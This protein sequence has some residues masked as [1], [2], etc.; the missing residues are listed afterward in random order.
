VQ[1]TLRRNSKKNGSARRPSMRYVVM[2]LSTLVFTASLDIKAQETAATSVVKLTVPIQRIEN[3]ERRNF[4]EN[5][6]AYAVKKTAQH[7]VFLS[8]W[9]CIDGFYDRLN[10]PT[11]THAGTTIF[12]TLVESGGNMD[13]DWLV[14]RTP[15]DVFSDSL[16]LAH[17]ASEKVKKGE[18]LYGFGW[19][20]HLQNSV[21]APKELTCLALDVGRKLTLNCGFAKGDSGGLVARKVKGRYE[22]V[23]IIS[24]GNS[25]TITYAY[26]LS[27]LPQRLLKTLLGDED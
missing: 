2:L 23:G 25:S 26:P 12:P 4:I 7:Y 8:S 18:I 24:A 27:A 16:A 5:C 9:H 19:G 6:S 14:L 15:N 13:E 21:S 11:I 17:P 22:A 10:L 3:H 20:G 1:D